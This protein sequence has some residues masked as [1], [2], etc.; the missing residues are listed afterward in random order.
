MKG[1]PE[2][3]EGEWEGQTTVE[4]SR[5]QPEAGEPPWREGEGAGAEGV[6]VPVCAPRRLALRLSRNWAWIPPFTSSWALGE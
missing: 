3:P 1:P 5:G 2:R 6:C 4:Q